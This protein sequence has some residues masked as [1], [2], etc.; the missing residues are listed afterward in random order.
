MLRGADLFKRVFP[1][2][3]AVQKKQSTANNDEATEEQGFQ[4]IVQTA[5]C[6]VSPIAKA[7]ASNDRQKA[8]SFSIASIAGG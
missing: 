6:T 7:S 8:A 3:T 2:H 5:V 4:M 1:E